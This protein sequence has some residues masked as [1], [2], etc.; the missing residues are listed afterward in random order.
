MESAEEPPSKRARQ[1]AA[2]PDPVVPSSD[3][4]ASAD[5]PDPSHTPSGS[6]IKDQNQGTAGQDQHLV[7]ETD[8]GI[9]EFV[10]EGVIRF[11]G[12]FKKR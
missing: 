11:S 3:Q 10:S 1:L 2:S 5:Q 8:V 7:Q 12:L 4:P 9:T 6:A